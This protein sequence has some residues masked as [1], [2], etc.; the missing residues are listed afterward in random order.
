[1]MDRYALAP[2]RELWL[3]EAMYDRWLEVE[4]AALRAL[5]GEGIVPQGTSRR[6]ASRA[7]VDVEATRTLEGE[8]GHDLVA[9]LWVLEGRLGS[10]GRWLHYGLTSSDVKDTALALVLR[11]AFNL[12]EEKCDAVLVSLKQ[13][14]DRHRRTLI[15]GRTHAQWGEPT[16]LG[17]KALAWRDLAERAGKR[18]SMAREAVAV[19]KLA[20]AVGT[21]AYYP[22]AAEARAL[23]ALGLAT[24]V[25]A[26]QV[27]PRDRHAEALFALATVGTFVETVAQEIR[28]LCRSEV[29]EVAEGRPEGSSAMPHKRNPILSER[30]CGLARILRSHVGP[31]LEDVALWHERDMTHSSVERVVLPQAFTLA[32]FALARVRTLIEGLRVYPE[33]MMG[34]LMAAQGLPF[35]EGLL[36]ALVR[37]GVSRREAHTR[38]R[39]LAVRAEDE[40]RELIEVAGEDQE[41]AAWLSDVELAEVFQLPELLEHLDAHFDRMC[42]GDG[43]HRNLAGRGTP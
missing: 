17:L 40:G 30:L 8:V 13:F 34:R 19:G 41:V 37:S 32:D 7:S 3:P 6:I 36:L 28:H 15:L 29:A 38:V 33:Q 42:P 1:M 31:G 4:L 27:V 9:F 39:S 11:D 26:G 20:G 23:D 21:C 24:C 10:E 25:P 22:A 14:A 35:S 43:Q 18:L 2:M 5:E 16:T 12:L